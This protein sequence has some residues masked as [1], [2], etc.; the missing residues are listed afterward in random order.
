MA[1][2]L[3]DRGRHNRPILAQARQTGRR[4]GSGYGRPGR[5]DAMNLLVVIL[6]VLLVVALVG[7]V[8]GR[9]RL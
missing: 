4:Q 5:N 2:H 6:I 9:R 8:R 7:G 3:P 1:V